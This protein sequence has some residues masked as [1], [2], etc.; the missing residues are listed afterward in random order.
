MKNVEK[1][2]VSAGFLQKPSVPK[3][4]FGMLCRFAVA[5][6]GT[7]GVC[8]MFDNAFA[9]SG[10]FEPLKIV[11]FCL[12]F[13]AAFFVLFFASDTNKWVYIAVLVIYSVLFGY[14]VYRVGVKELFVYA[15]VALWDHILYKLSSF[16]YNALTGLIIKIDYVTVNTAVYAKTGFYAFCSVISFIFTSC[17]Y[18][19]VKAVPVI[20]S[21]GIVMTVTFTYNLITDNFG[22]V[23]VVSSGCGILV[24]LYYA[25]FTKQK[26]AKDKAKEKQ[27]RIRKKS[28]ID[29]ASS[30]F[31][32][33]LASVLVLSVALYPASRIDK[34]APEFSFIYDVIDDMRQVFSEYLTGERIDDGF[35][36]KKKSV[37]PAAR[38]FRDKKMLTVTASYRSP[39]YLRAWVSEKYLNDSWESAS[40][41]NDTILPE[42]V[43]ELFY[44]V[45]DVDANILTD[46]DK[47]DTGSLKRGFVK[48]FVTVKS[49]SV[50]GYAGITPSRFSTIYGITDTNIDKPYPREYTLRNGAGTIELS[51][52]GAQYGAVAYSPDYRNVD[53][54]KLDGDMKIYNIV[55]PYIEEYIQRRLDGVDSVAWLDSIIEL[56][57][58][59]AAQQNVS[60][61]DGC[62]INYVGSMSDDDLKEFGAKIQKVREYE[63]HVYYNCASVPWSDEK[64]LVLAAHEAYDGRAAL[65]PSDVYAYAINTARYLAEKCD[66]TL[67]PSGYTDS[68]SYVS[69]FLTTAKNGYCVQYATAGALMLRT[70]GIPTRYADGYLA[71]DLQVKNNRY[72]CTVLDKNAHAWV[73][74]Y[75]KN[76][77]WMTFEMTEPMLSGIYSMRTQSGYTTIDTEVS[78]A[79]EVTT[80][81]TAA[82]ETTDAITTPRDT[83]TDAESTTGEPGAQ[84]K[85]VPVKA[86][87][88][89]GAVFLCVL[90]ISTLIFIYLK[91]TS[92]K[93]EKR[94]KTIQNAKNSKST[95]PSGDIEQISGYIFRLFGLSGLK[96]E[97]TELMTDF[98]KRAD[99]LITAVS[100]K[101]AAD[102]IQKNSY[103]HCAGV[104]DCKTVAD[105]ADALRQITLGTLPPGKKFLYHGVLKLI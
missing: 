8:L 48:E 99:G 41:D 23:M 32:A 20:I 100:F 98:V 76:Y 45:V 84:N 90:I 39:L 72:V 25:S 61:P 21:A 11:L 43:T 46:A 17:L 63:D 81:T 6:L 95:D 10:S 101:D 51:M 55:M 82:P 49:N 68:G 26:K 34:P 29:A 65:L 85:N 18:K 79:P 12:A 57:H 91:V 47:A 27:F 16:G 94:Q 35:D 103:G 75:V 24:M 59:K 38:E 73:E 37:M 86:L 89:A 96:K 80:D 40:P 102:V 19:K 28:L 1:S 7:A 44:T 50:K 31:A 67:S 52:K 9:F 62:L 64:K 69:Q 88:T 60:I 70:A 2:A 5:F 15:P 58:K 83:Q 71:S 33:A 13:C 14:T 78:T 42:Q 3:I 4:I 56:T 53:F 36:A 93:A 87:M 66:Y 97:K 74:V 77:G 92:A 22:F 105:Y 104:N 54:D 30:G